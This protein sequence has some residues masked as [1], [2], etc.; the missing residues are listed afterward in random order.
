MTSINSSRYKW[1]VLFVLTLVFAL[2]FFDRQLIVI[3]QEPIKAELGLTDTQLGLLTGLSFAI[4][5]SV[6]GIPIARFSDRNNRRNV[7]SAAMAVWSIFTAFTGSVQNFLQMFLVRMGVGV[8][9][10]GSGPASL[11][12]IA[13]YFPIEKRGRAFAIYS[14][15]IYIGLFLSFVLAG[16][17]VDTWGWRKTFFFLGAPGIAFAIFLLFIIKEPIRGTSEKKKVVHEETNFSDTLRFLFTRKTFIWVCI[18][19][20]MHSFVGYSFAN[21]MPSFFMRVHEMALAEVG[22]WLAISIG[23]GGALGALIGGIFVDHLVKKDRRWYMWLAIGSIFLTI[24]FSLFTLLSG[25]GTAAVICYFIPNFLYSFNMG[26]MLT[27]ILGVVRVEMRAF[28]SSIYYFIINLVGLG[29]GPLAVG[30]LSDAL[31][32]QFNEQSLRYSLL[33]ISTVNFVAVYYYWKASQSLEL[34]MD[35]VG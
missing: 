17:L 8:G 19:N 2:N 28:T 13:D 27:V 15:G 1:F 35:A 25:N 5:Y 31:L 32:P 26:A 16:V 22:L 34:E 4:F 7:I 29:L 14:M 11:S 24:P 6:L 12:I 23:I 21:W 9:E 33:I 20:A 30:I 18:G 10:A 3:L